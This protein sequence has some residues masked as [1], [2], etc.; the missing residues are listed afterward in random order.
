MNQSIPDGLESLEYRLHLP[1][2]VQDGS[3]VLILLHGRGSDERDLAGFARLLPE[4]TALVTPRAPFAGRPWGYGSGWAWYRY[5]SE[6]RVVDETLHTSL[7]LL[8]RLFHDVRGALSFEPGP[9]FLGGFSQG[10]TTSLAWALTRSSS[11]A[12]IVNLSGFLVDAQAVEVSEETA[13]GLPV[14][15]GHGRGDPNIPF[16]LAERGRGRLQVAGALLHE[17]DHPGGHNVTPGEMQALREWMEE[18][19]SPRRSP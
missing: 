1:E 5:V 13:G 15:W 11:L 4:A 19:S 2:D 17:V 12:G 6:D 18:R 10:G 16:S 14:F 9:Q 8:D 7:A 3:P